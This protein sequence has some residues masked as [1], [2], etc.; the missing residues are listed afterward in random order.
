[1][2]EEAGRQ[3]DRFLSKEHREVM[4][5]GR[6]Q[7]WASTIAVGLSSAPMGLVSSAD[8]WF[9]VNIGSPFA[10]PSFTTLSSLLAY[11]WTTL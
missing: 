11:F 4:E 8:C 6:P 1:M 2:N 9:V 3:F 5:R 10:T 7:T